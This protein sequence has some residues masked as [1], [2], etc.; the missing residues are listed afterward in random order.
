MGQ[1]RKN[2]D[3]SMFEVCTSDSSNSVIRTPN[4][5]FNIKYLKRTIMFDTM[6]WNCMSANGLVCLYILSGAQ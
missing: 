6:V 5:G 3:E 2:C 4:E 1:D